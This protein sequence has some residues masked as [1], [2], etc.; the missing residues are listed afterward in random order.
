MK[1]FPIS[2]VF[3]IL[4]LSLSL[5]VVEILEILD[6]S[7][8]I[9]SYSTL[10]VVMLICVVFFTVSVYRQYGKTMFFSFSM[11]FFLCQFFLQICIGNFG[12]YEKQSYFNPGWEYMN[13]TVK[14]LTIG[15]M[16]YI[17]GLNT[18]SVQRHGEIINRKIVSMVVPSQIDAS[19]GRCILVFV[20]VVPIYIWA[21]G[22][23]IVGYAT[24]SGIANYDSN[25]NSVQLIT[26]ITNMMTM[27]VYVLFINMI[28][29]KTTTSKIILFII[30][31]VRLSLA[32][33]SGMKADI[34]LLVAS[35]GII[36]YILNGKI[37]IK[38]IAGAAIATLLIYMLNETYRNLLRNSTYEGMERMDVLLHAIEVVFTGNR[39]SSEDVGID[40]LNRIGI[41]ESAAAI[42]YYSD[43]VGL[44]ES[45][46]TFLK[47][48][49]LIPFNTFLPRAVFPWK[50]ILN[51]GLWV[52]RTVYDSMSYSSSYLTIVGFF[53]LIG[54]SVAVFLGYFLIAIFLEFLS[55]IVNIK[56]K[57]MALLCTYLIL[58]T[59]EIYEPG[60]PVTMI[61]GLLRGI[62]IYPLLSVVLTKKAGR[63][64]VNGQ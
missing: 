52:T 33:L 48:L 1:R 62:I 31:G 8:N 56:S 4:L 46:P 12:L 51:Y 24:L 39:G 21:L 45:D 47:D 40:M 41:T 53:Y 19:I 32:L 35:L 42:I 25:L 16:G 64:K 10:T 44:T 50:S 36:Y 34:I 7:N 28:Q 61:M 59:T 29:K 60:D 3:C 18:V 55:G 57:N 37:T 11:V 22:R 20:V 26:Y 15:T 38:M 30:L 54:G 5:I 23:G 9:T 49:L 6:I 14:I 17:C 27:V 13:K 2:K 63:Q 58:L 43:T